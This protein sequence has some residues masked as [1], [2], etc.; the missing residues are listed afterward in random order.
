[1]K[2]CAECGLVN[3]D[4][5]ESCPA[6]DGRSWAPLP[7]GIPGAAP[8]APV[9]DPIRTSD[10]TDGEDTV[11]CPACTEPNPGWLTRCRRCHGALSGGATVVAGYEAG[12][13]QQGVTMTRGHRFFAFTL[14]LLSIPCTLL[15]LVHLFSVMARWDPE[16][17]PIQFVSA[18][19]LLGITG[20]VTW[21]GGRY[22]IFRKT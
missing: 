15:S 7:P 10:A 13:V 5:A 21:F 20:T 19:I 9:S 4:E 16:A 8:L 12:A 18:V 22:W 1:M 14:W 2:A 11:I 6:C 3:P 17:G